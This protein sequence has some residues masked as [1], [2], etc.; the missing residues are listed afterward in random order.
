SLTEFQDLPRPNLQLLTNMDNRLIKEALEFY[1]NKSKMEHQQLRPLLN[2]KQ[3]LIYE[4]VIESMHYQRGHFYFMCGPGGTGK[5]F[6]YKTIIS[7]LR[8]ERKIVLAVASSGECYYLQ[9]LLNV[10]RGPQTLKELMT[11]NNRVCASFKAG[12]FAYGL[13][14]DD[15]EWTRAISEASF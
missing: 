15:R 7:R 12:C 14:N 9:M 6:L 5:T 1:M 2:P 8:S 4:E 10:V 13:L 11:V 3:H